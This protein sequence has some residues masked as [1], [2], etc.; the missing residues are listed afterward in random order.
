[1][2][3]IEIKEPLSLSDEQYS[4]LDMH[5]VLNISNVLIGE[6]TFL[7][8][9]L[10]DLSLVQDSLD[11]CYSVADSLK[12]K[13]QA[14]EN[15]HNIQEL[16]SAIRNNLNQTVHT[17]EEKKDEP[18]I[19]EFLDN[20][21]SIFGILDVRTQEILDRFNTPDQWMSYNI[22]HLK[23]NFI[24]LFSAIEQNSKGR[25]H[26]VYNIASQNAVYYLVNLN[27]TSAD[28]N[29]IKM[30]PL[31]QDVMR[32]LIANARK[33]TPVGGTIS[34]GLDDDGEFLRLVVED[35]GKGIPGDQLESVVKF[36]FR[37]SNVQNKQTKGGGFG[38]TK[39]YWVTRQNN[40]RMCISSG[41]NE[42]TK[43]EI[44]M[45]VRRDDQDT[46]TK[47]ERMSTPLEAEIT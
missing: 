30:P 15:L 24:N 23:Q 29:Y 6:L 26:F 40:G 31:L 2:K 17:N 3:K 20:I 35:N 43:I 18:E 13:N 33:Y 38:L 28:G 42:G 8:D 7:G 4:L 39:A 14:L 37:A 9:A 36:G 47:K 19:R 41:E 45:P 10:G 12:D 32:D 34:A 16:K 11:V 22:D 25:Y 5:S 27:I 1:M 44:E 46:K 21:S